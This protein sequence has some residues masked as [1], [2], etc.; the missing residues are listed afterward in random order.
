M[1]LTDIE[2]EDPAFK[3][4]VLATGLETAE[5]ITELKC[6]KQSISSASGIEHFPNLKLLDLTRNKLTELD[7]SHNPLLEELYLG[8]NRIEA[9]DLS[10]NPNLTHLEIFINEIA[11]LDLTV[12]PKLE[13]LYANANDLEVIDLSSNTD[14]DEI[15]VSDNN[16][17]EIRLPEGCKPTVFKAENNMLPEAQKAHLRS[18]VDSHRCKV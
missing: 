12:T 7:V 10:H 18:L 2:F 1:K 11:E 15:L 5:E 8:N 16:L 14:I 17:R 6:R 13:N 9:L 4:C 3:A